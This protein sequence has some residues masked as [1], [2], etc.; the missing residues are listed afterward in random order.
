MKTLKMIKKALRK[1]PENKKGRLSGL[2]MRH[3]GKLVCPKISIKNWTVKLHNKAC[4][5]HAL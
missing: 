5:N 2:L 4:T 1:I 3:E